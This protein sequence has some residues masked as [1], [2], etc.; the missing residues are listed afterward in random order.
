MHSIT[1]ERAIGTYRVLRKLGEGGMGSVYEAEHLSI[2]RRVAIKVLHPIYS[3]DPEALARFYNEA[4]AANLIDHPSVV[5][6]LDYG[7]QEDGSFYF[8]MELLK[9]ETL[10][11]RIERS[12]KDVGI[13]LDEA[14]RI[15]RQLASTLAAA[16][17]CGIIHRDLKP[18]NIMLIPDPEATDGQRVKILDFGIA[19]LAHWVEGAEVRTRTNMVFGTPAYMA[20]EQCRSAAQV[21]DRADVYSLGVVLFELLAGRRPFVGSSAG[22]YMGQHLFCA[23]PS[24]DTLIPD[25][26]SEL[27]KLTAS[28]L[29]KNRESRPRMSQV[30]A[31]LEVL[32]GARPDSLATVNHEIEPK[33]VPEPETDA[34]TRMAANNSSASPAQLTAQMLQRQDAQVRRSWLRPAA[35]GCLLLGG[36]LLSRSG[37]WSP[38]PP[39]PQ[40]SAVPGDSLPDFSVRAASGLYTGSAEPLHPV[41]TVDSHV[42]QLPPKRIHRTAAGTPFATS[43]HPPRSVLPSVRGTRSHAAAAI[44]SGSRSRSPNEAMHNEILED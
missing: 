11:S 6:I 26:P 38:A 12:K 4:R 18:E 35:L 5:Q 8:I 19:K 34:P 33:A 15:G 3:N 21:D 29:C 2:A 14:L 13:S 37:H 25:V 40:A 31:R 39:I 36:V 10:R 42:L 23:P 9:G 16:H 17:G 44:P 43:R 32:C 28:L 41:L 20:P 22:E 30:L 24:I 1:T 27:T 7:Q